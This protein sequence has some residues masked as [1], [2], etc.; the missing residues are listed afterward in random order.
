MSLNDLPDCDLCDGPLDKNS[1]FHEY[2]DVPLCEGCL[3]QAIIDDGGHQLVD[4]CAQCGTLW[5]IYFLKR[6]DPRI[7]NY[8][9]NDLVCPRCGLRD[10]GAELRE[11]NRVATEAEIEHAKEV[12][13][14]SIRALNET[15]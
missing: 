10:Y 3:E 7:V 4:A 12:V 11:M 1:E 13:R 14:R 8:T 5:H 9:D 6:H 15:T 2:N